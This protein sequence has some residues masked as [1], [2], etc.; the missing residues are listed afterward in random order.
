MPLS[1]IQIF[2]GP[3]DVSKH[4]KVHC[5]F[6]HTTSLTGKHCGIFFSFKTRKPAQK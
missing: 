2:H 5:I 1:P 3:R 4:K 6:G